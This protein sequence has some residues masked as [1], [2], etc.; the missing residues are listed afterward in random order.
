MPDPKLRFR[1]R[2]PTVD[3]N[4]PISDG[5]VKVEGF[6]LE[7][8]DVGDDARFAADARGEGVVALDDRGA[9]DVEEQRLKLHRV[10]PSKARL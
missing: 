3:T 1:F 7:V 2:E 4:L 8:M 6:D 9:L 5:T 10:P